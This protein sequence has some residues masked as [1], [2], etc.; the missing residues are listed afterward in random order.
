MFAHVDLGCGFLERHTADAASIGIDVNFEHG[1]AKPMNPIIADV[2]YIPVRS[3]CIERVY[4]RAVL[5]HLR[6]AG[7]CLWDMHRIMRGGA[8][9]I[10]LIPV[11]ANMPRQILRRFYKEFP[12]SVGWVLSKLWRASTLWR[13][14]SGMT[15]VTQLG[16]ED[17]EKYF[18]VDHNNI[19]SHRRVHKWFVHYGPFV[20]LIKLGVLKSRLTVDEYADITFSIEKVS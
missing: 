9:G 4:A 20:L 19:V 3:G 17:V 5:E 8:T 10:V 18:R 6:R 12:F 1:V 11:E 13:R 16:V 15:H 14:H 2:Q 7:L